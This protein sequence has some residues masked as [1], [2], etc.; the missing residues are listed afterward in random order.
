[1]GALARL[2]LTGV[3]QPTGTSPFVRQWAA[4]GQHTCTNCKMNAFL[5]DPEIGFSNL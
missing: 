4:F 2:G 3:N 5:I 1:M